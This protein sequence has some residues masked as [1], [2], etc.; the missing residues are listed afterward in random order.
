MNTS[1][2]TLASGKAPASS[3]LGTFS[4]CH[5]GLLAQLDSLSHLPALA[6][7][8]DRARQTAHA[9]VEAFEEA[10]TTHHAEEE[11][12][13]FPAVL[14]SAADAAERQR[15][16][17]MVD[18]LTREHRQV[19]AAW[20]AL[21]PAIRK[22][23]K[24]QHGELDGSRVAALVELYHAHASYEEQSF[25]PLSQDILGRDGNHMAALGMSL[26]MRHAMPEVLKRYGHL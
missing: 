4:Q 20:K 17:G 19:E 21:A 9:L 26:H 15:V 8:A 1:R 22:I 13:L 10:I 18:R 11:Q 14:A 6:A 7:A 25:L 5:A 12:E 3:P 16:Q 2:Y 24:G 23:A